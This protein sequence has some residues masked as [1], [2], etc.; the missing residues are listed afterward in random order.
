M[1]RRFQGRHLVEGD[2]GSSVVIVSSLHKAE[3]W[4]RAR[5]TAG[6]T[7]GSQGLGLRKGEGAGMKGR[8]ARGC[9]GRAKESLAFIL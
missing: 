2:W 8:E 4:E 5:F 9:G 1:N 6:P 3:R 7:S